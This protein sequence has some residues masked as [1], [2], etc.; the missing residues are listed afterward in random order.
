ML[1]VWTSILAFAIVF[2]SQS[3]P[4]ASALGRNALDA[5]ERYST[6]QLTLTM[7]AEATVNG[8]SEAE[9]QRAKVFYSKADGI[10]IEADDALEISEGQTTWVYSNADNEYRRYR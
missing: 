7:L 3:L 8:K 6:I 9:T 1:S 4:E 2:Q 5:R 10:R